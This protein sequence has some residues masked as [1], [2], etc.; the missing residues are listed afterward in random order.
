[1]NFD[2]FIEN[3]LHYYLL[4]D[5]GLKKQ[6]N[7]YIEDYVQTIS[8]WDK[9][10]LNDVLFLF[11]QE[12]CDTKK[13][14]FMGIGR[15]GNGRI[16]Y[17][18]DM[19]L[20]DYLYSECLENKMPQLR[21]FYELYKNDKFGVMYARDM[22]DRAYLSTDCD[23]KTVALLF[24]SWLGVLEWGAHHFPEACIITKD[25]MRNA[26]KQC[27]KIISEKEV[28]EALK[29]ELHYYE[30]LYQCYYKYEDEGISKSFQEYCDEANIE[31]HND[32]ITVY[33]QN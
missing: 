32:I 30:L 8:A 24:S 5:Q 29:K 13:Y 2:E 16:P 7:K 14:D 28:N 26:V 33:F 18:L 25:E 21:W 19:L 11:A 31:F 12:L 23:Q 6:A 27:K 1:M 20:R 15:R 22:L 3:V 17:A 4:Y 9:Q 10:E